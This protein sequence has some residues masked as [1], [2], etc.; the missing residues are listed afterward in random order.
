MDLTISR[1]DDHLLTKWYSK[2]YA[3]YRLTNWFSG[4]DKKVTTNTAINHVKNMLKST[5]PIYKEEV[6]YLAFQILK[7]NS[8][9]EP[10]IKNI[11]AN[12]NQQ[13]YATVETPLTYVGMHH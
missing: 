8:F 11:I 9:P 2:P 4:H 13:K 12:V 10:V 6:E 5:S 1:N 7:L 3:S